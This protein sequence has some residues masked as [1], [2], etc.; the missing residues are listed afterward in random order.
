MLE[1]RKNSCRIFPIFWRDMFGIW[2]RQVRNFIRTDSTL[3]SL[4]ILSFHVQLYLCLLS[5]S[6]SS[7]SLSFYVFLCFLLFRVRKGPRGSFTTWLYILSAL[8]KKKCEECILYVDYEILRGISCEIIFE[9]T[10]FLICGKGQMFR[11]VVRFLFSLIVWAKKIVHTWH[12]PLDPLVA[13]T[14]SQEILNNLAR[15]LFPA[16]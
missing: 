8:I 14:M 6:A 9:E 11:K 13:P 5:I 7:L 3:Y 2:I 12:R 10:F 4:G 15:H 16:K 1:S